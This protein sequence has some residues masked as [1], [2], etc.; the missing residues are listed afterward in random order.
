MFNLVAHFGN[1]AHAGEVHVDKAESTSHLLNTWYTALPLALVTVVLVG[2]LAYYL[3]QKSKS[4][5]FLAVNVAL[6]AIGVF[7]Y[8]R[9]PV[10]SVL[11]LSLGFAMCL[12]GALATLLSTGAKK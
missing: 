6:L 11:S 12:A 8:T 10:V 9:S 7:A 1:F 5:A 2:V 3:F 4:S